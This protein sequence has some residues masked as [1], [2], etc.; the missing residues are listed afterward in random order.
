M[1]PYLAQSVSV[2]LQLG[3]NTS[4][5]LQHHNTITGTSFS[6]CY[7]DY[8][9]QLENALEAGSNSIALLKVRYMP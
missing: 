3:R 2:D 1:F 9:K 5:L 7:V 4:A 8:N 6:D